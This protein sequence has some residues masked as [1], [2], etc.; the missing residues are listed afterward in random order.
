MRLS[1][2]QGRHLRRWGIVFLSLVFFHVPLITSMAQN[3]SVCVREY[4]QEHPLIYEE[5]WDLWPYAFL[6][7]NGEP[8]GYNVDLVRLIMKRLN[9]PYIIKL[10][11]S[12]EVFNDLKDGK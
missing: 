11:S 1:Y 6:N 7:D 3:D 8:E 12:E 5:V 2:H 4:T 10:K 9:I